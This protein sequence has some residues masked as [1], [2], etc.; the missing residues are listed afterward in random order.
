VQDLHQVRDYPVGS[1]RRVVAQAPVADG[2]QDIDGPE[3]TGALGERT[4]G[5]PETRL[6]DDLA[7][8]QAGQIAGAY[9][10]V[11]PIEREDHVHRTGAG[12]PHREHR[13]HASR[14]RLA[15]YPYRMDLPD[16]HAVHQRPGDPNPYLG[17][18]ALLQREHRRAGREHPAFVHVAGGDC[19]RERR[20]EV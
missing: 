7:E 14:H 9:A 19:G 8:G 17:L 2:L 20:P 13:L 3:P 18:G 1:R 12:T 6:R 15:T 4:D 11:I 16:R 5:K 10:H